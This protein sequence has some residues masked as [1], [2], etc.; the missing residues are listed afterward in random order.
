MAA[1]VAASL[2]SHALELAL[3]PLETLLLLALLLQFLLLLL[4]TLGILV[5]GVI[6]TAVCRRWPLLRTILSP[7]LV[8]RVVL[9]LVLISCYCLG[10][11]AFAMQLCHQCVEVLRVLGRPVVLHVVHTNGALAQRNAVKVVH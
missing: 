9:G 5:L 4:E 11:A 6:P 1:A 8:L 3:L 2:G 10:S 7:H